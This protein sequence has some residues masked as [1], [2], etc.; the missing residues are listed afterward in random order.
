MN[1]TQHSI[2]DL[3]ISSIPPPFKTQSNISFQCEHHKWQSQV[4]MSEGCTH[5]KDVR[6]RQA[7]TWKPPGDAPVS[8]S[9]Q[10]T[11]LCAGQ[12]WQGSTAYPVPAWQCELTPTSA[13]PLE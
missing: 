10:G 8:P 9:P 6:Q 12:G 11:A 1:E 4:P 13:L 7:V 3:Q 2:I 5:L